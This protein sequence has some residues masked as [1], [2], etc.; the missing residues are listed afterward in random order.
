VIGRRFYLVDSSTAGRF[1][2]W[3]QRRGRPGQTFSRSAGGRKAH[4]ARPCRSRER[5][6][7]TSWL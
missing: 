1:S 3:L 5:W 2:W 6:G 4:R 7:R